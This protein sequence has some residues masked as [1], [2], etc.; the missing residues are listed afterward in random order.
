LNNKFLGSSFCC[1]FFILAVCLILTACNSTN[2]K[3]PGISIN[4]SK[5][6]TANLALDK[7]NDLIIEI[8]NRGEKAI[9]Y[10]MIK[11]TFK[12]QQDILHRIDFTPI[13][14]DEKMYMLDPGGNKNKYKPL[15]PGNK[16][17]YGVDLT[18]LSF[19]NM[20]AQARLERNWNDLTVQT[21]IVKVKFDD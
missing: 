17:S 2:D 5:S 6:P 12:N 21:R 19:L 11:V 16:L 10:L 8:D 20:E 1:Y 18:S 13:W 15:E 14:A 9:S 4:I 7:V 3:Y